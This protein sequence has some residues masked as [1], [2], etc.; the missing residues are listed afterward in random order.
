LAEA[1]GASTPYG[2]QHLL[3][4]ARWDADAVRDD[5][6][7]CVVTSWGRRPRCW[8]STRAGS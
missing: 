4:R 7:A 8:W 5:L 6:R 3:G 1:A 2:V